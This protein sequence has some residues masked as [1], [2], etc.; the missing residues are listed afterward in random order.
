MKRTV[1]VKTYTIV[2]RA[3]EEGVAYGLRRYSK[4]H[5]ATPL[6][7][8]AEYVEREVMNAL[9]EVIDFDEQEN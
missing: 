3:V 6:D 4:Y 2:A 7:A 9:S 1:K 5:D 8:V